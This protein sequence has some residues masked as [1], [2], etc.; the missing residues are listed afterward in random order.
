M[1]LVDRLRS[2]LPKWL[3]PGIVPEKIPTSS[4]SVKEDRTASLRARDYA[5]DAPPQLFD[6][7]ADARTERVD[8]NIAI[9]TRIVTGA[10]A[11]LPIDVS[12]VVNDGGKLSYEED[13]SHPAAE[14]LRIP[15]FYHMTSEVI[16]DIV[17]SLVLCGNSY[18]AIEKKG[19]Q[20]IL[21]LWPLEPSKVEIALDRESG[22][23][24]G[25]HYERFGFGKPRISYALDELLHIRLWNVND[26]WYG[27]SGVQS[28]HSKIMLNWYVDRYNNGFFRN[29]AG[30]TKALFPSESMS[31]EEREITE[32][33]LRGRSSPENFGKIVVMPVGGDIKNIGSEQKDL[34]FLELLQNNREQILAVFGIPPFLAGVMEFANYANALVQEQS[35]WRHT[36]KPLCEIISQSMTRQIIWQH[37]DRE[38]VFRFDFSGVDALRPDELARAQTDAILVR[39][40]IV[41]INEARRSRNM[42]PVDWGDEPI[43]QLLNPIAPGA[44][45][46]G[47]QEVDPNKE[48]KSDLFVGPPFVRRSAPQTPR[49]IKW[50]AFD[51]RVR[52]EEIRFS[53]IIAEYFQGQGARVIERLDKFTANGKFMAAIMIAMKD[54]P[55]SPDPIFPVGDE[56][57]ILERSVI[58]AFRSTIGRAG[59]DAITDIGVSASFNVNNPSVS[60]A[61]SQFFN[62]IRNINDTSYEI[63]KGILRQ[64]NDEG[65]SIERIQK[66]L[67][68]NFLEFSRERAVRIART[69]MTGVVNRG[70]IIAYEQIGVETK[71]WLAT[72]DE[73]TRDSH[74]AADG[75]VV[76]IDQPFIRTGYPMDAPG[77]PTAPPGQVIN[78]RCAV[79][80]GEEKRFPIRHPEQILS[81]STN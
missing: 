72:Q 34:S 54:A 25:Y 77:D 17:Q 7:T 59:T 30:V 41:T 63:I 38:H 68:R 44:A 3:R 52:K 65:W 15:N 76:P 39:S 66:E 22:L 20:T 49:A 21:E 46:D 32:K 47:T 81:L 12:R 26:R 61:V 67:R 75:E 73:V 4:P 48:A 13:N 50:K 9:I 80:A 2:N 23:P 79:T 74:A 8:A 16:S 64:A 69:E 33:A 19:G 51:Q 55:D 14:L 53:R 60:G 43:L 5:D 40:G 56:D 1:G 62:R 78:C 31:A 58:P 6:I 11:H 29:G 27:R 10:V 70:T 57:V 37:F 36:I 28:V 45:T 35:F 24:L 18:T 71:E 42:D